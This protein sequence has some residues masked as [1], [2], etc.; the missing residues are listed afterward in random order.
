MI[1]VSFT[2]FSK[3]YFLNITENK[4]S[5]NQI[6]T[7]T[8]NLSFLWEHGTSVCLDFAFQRKTEA[9]S[10]EGFSDCNQYDKGDEGP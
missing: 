8:S 7:F 10:S 9:S 4:S 3:R 1:I 2:T 5:Q 6:N